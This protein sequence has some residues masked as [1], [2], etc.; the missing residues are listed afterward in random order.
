[1][2]RRSPD[3]TEARSLPKK[4][5]FEL[6]PRG[7][8]ASGDLAASVFHSG[9]RRDPAVSKGRGRNGGGGQLFFLLAARAFDI[10]PR[11]DYFFSAQTFIVPQ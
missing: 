8:V 3:G 5:A 11:K 2:R 1:M 4:Q 10:G 6:V 7:G 9:R